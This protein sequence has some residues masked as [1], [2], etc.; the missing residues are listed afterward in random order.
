MITAG[1][2]V[3]LTVALIVASALALYFVRFSG[4][5]RIAR[6]RRETE[7]L[8]LRL[9]VVTASYMTAMRAEVR[10]HRAAVAGVDLARIDRRGHVRR[11]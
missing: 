2:I 1:M 3:L 5:A 8:E 4:R 11:F 10:R 9:N 6:V 7:L